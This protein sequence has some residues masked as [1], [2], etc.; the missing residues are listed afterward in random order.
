MMQGIDASFDACIFVGYHARAG[1]APAILDHTIS[2]SSIRA[3]RINGRELPELGINAAIAGYYKVPVVMISGDAETC[4]QAKTI[5]G[6][7][8]VAAPVKEAVGRLAARLLPASEA[9]RL[10]K[11]AASDALARRGKMT[12]FRLDPPCSFE[13]EFFN[14]LQAEMPSYLP[15]VKRPNARTVAFAANDYLEG[16]K[17]MRAII[18]LAGIAF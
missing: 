16:F 15:Q 3:I 14:S 10:L 7:E 18:A 2:S 5:L 4:A 9:R 1:T 8:L 17:L 13:I 6:Q 12:P 11:Q